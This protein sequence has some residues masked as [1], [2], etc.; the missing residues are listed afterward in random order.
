MTDTPDQVGGDDPLLRRWGTFVTGNAIL[1]SQSATATQNA[2][3]TTTVD[4]T[5]G[6]DYRLSKEW[7]IG[8]LGGYGRTT[9]DLDSLGSRLAMNN[10]RFGPYGS[11]TRGDWYINGRGYYGFNVGTV[12]RAVPITNAVAQ[13]KPDG[14]QYGV[15][16]DTGYKFHAGNL[17][18][19]PVLG[20]QY[21]HINIGSYME[22]GAGASNLLI[23]TQSVDSFV[24]NLGGR[25]SYDF[26]TTWRR[27]TIRPQLDA[28]WQHECLDTSHTI[29]EAFVV[30][31]TG[32][33]TVNASGLPRDAAV[34]GGG[35]SMILNS[36]SLVFVRYDAQIGQ[37][38]YSAQSITGGIRIVY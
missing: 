24:A 17:T 3:D 26:H 7:T 5:V 20:G 2:V 15:A 27:L 10:Y 37:E 29:G 32:A 33:F 8:F 34:L 4:F 13:G 23:G 18:Y 16:F 9:A 31:G 1:A 11:Y 19:G 35:V 21:T 38:N 22:T 30:P 25:V 36:G 28:S 12:T 14:D 6:T